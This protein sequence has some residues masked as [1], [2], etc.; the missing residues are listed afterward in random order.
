MSKIN[1]D[2]ALTKVK[3]GE[4]CIPGCK[5][6]T[7]L[8]VAPIMRGPPLYC[9]IHM[10]D[11]E[12]THSGSYTLKSRDCCW[13]CCDSSWKLSHCYKFEAQFNAY[14]SEIPVTEYHQKML[15][16]REVEANEAEMERQRMEAQYSAGHDEYYDR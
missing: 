11:G 16:Q 14:A 2:E 8:H 1:F 13:T 9:P 10:A 6:R 3:S 12:L 5:G 4:C 15:Q 7:E